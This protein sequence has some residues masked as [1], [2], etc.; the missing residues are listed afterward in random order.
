[1]KFVEDTLSDNYYKSDLLEK[2]IE[3]SKDICA[4]ILYLLKLI[5]LKADVLGESVH[6]QKKEKSQKI[7]ILEKHVTFDKLNV[8]LD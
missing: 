8:V 7:I 4:N 1:M 2:E 3:C 6:I 5:I